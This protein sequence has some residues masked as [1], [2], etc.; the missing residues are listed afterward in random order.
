MKTGRI[1]SATAPNFRAMLDVDE[2]AAAK[3]IDS[4]APNTVPVEEVGHSDTLTS[5][6]DSL[7]GSIF[8]TA[9]EA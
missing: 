2:T 1:S 8:P 5:A 4:L 7:Y 3:V 9:K 6:E